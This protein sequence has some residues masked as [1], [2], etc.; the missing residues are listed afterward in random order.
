MSLAAVGGGAGLDACWETVRAGQARG[1]CWTL[2]IQVRTDSRP[3]AIPL[4][5]TT[6]SEGGLHAG[7]MSAY[8]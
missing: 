6:R 5:L 1:G 2:G 8:C 3:L 7:E 4:E